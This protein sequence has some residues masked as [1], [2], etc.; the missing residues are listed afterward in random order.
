MSL[1]RVRSAFCVKNKWNSYK[2]YGGKI[3]YE[4]INKFLKAKYIFLFF[5]VIIVI[6]ACAFIG[7]L[8]DR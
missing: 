1:E 5:H 2:R 8:Y 7:Y 3:T 4:Y 6:S